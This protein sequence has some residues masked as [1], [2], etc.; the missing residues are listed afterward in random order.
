[1]KKSYHSSADPTAEA[2]SACM[3]RLDVIP[4]VADI[5][6]PDVSFTRDCSLVVYTGRPYWQAG[7][8]LSLDLPARRRPV[9]SRS[10]SDAEQPSRGAA[11]DG[12]PL[13][14]GQPWRVEHEINLGAGPWERVVGAD[15]DLP[16]TG[17]GDQVAQG[18]GSEDDRVEEE[19][20]ILQVSGR[21]LLRQ[22]PDPVGE[23]AGHGVGAVG[24]GRQ[25]AAAMRGTDLQSGEA[26]ED[27]K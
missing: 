3:T 14:V 18:F 21:V 16:R 10:G 24:I 2:I 19:L 25:E 27:R 9:G 7:V 6:S 1:M 23:A 11:Q 12:N 26:V 4:V 20:A 17:F 15:H 22:R 8:V 13:V 5:V